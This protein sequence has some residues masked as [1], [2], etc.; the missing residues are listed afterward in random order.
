MV[1]TFVN[2]LRLGWIKEVGYTGPYTMTDFDLLYI[3][4]LNLAF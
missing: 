3:S 1:H 4:F 2:E